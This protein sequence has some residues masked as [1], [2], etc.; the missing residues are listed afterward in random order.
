ML[1]KFSTRIVPVFVLQSEGELGHLV[2]NYVDSQPN[3][4]NRTDKRR[5]VEEM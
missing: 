3:Y 2:M 5:I 4:G 1:G